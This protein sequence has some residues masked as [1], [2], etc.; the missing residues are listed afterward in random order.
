MKATI[1]YINSELA[2]LYPVSEIEGFT[3]IIFEVVCGWSFTEQVV[4]KHD[5]VLKTDFSNIQKIVFR[6]KKFEPIQY[7]LGETEFYGL[8]IKVNPSVLIPRPETEELVQWITQSKLPVNARILDIGTGSGC[9]ALALKSLLKN[10]EVF[11]VDVSENALVVARQNAIENSLDVVFF[12]S[13][14]LN[15]KECEWKIYDV[16][17][18]NPPYIRESEKKQ[19]HANVLEYEPSNALFVND[20]DPLVFYRA[21]SVFSKK[22]LAKNGKLFFEI[23]EN[24]GLEMNELLLEYGFRYI[25]MRKDINDK[26]RMVSCRNENI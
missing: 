15:W 1:Q 2:G 4:K 19:M 24:L 11:G 3:R 5:K 8:K 7:I 10:A 12:Q 20:N 25:E 14:I 17:V 16:I 18:S 22:Y 23:N 26:T 13:D 21:I 6:L 9:I